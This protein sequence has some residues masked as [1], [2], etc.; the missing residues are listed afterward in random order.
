MRLNREPT[1]ERHRKAADREGLI[2]ALNEESGR[3]VARY[4]EL[5]VDNIDRPSD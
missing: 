3:D 4:P 2:E 1:G 5:R